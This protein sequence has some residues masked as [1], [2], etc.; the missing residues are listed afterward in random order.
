MKEG[1]RGREERK[2][3]GE[4]E[5]GGGR[6]E[7]RKREE[8]RGR[9]REGR[10]EGEEKG[11]GGK[12]RLGQAEPVSPLSSLS[13]PHRSPTL[14]PCTGLHNLAGRGHSRLFCFYKPCYINILNSGSEPT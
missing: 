1:E 9:G 11:G 13:N 10:K 4:G 6:K 5:G 14:P 12:K 7:R 8:R 3:K 2:R